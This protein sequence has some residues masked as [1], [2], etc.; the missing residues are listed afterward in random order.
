M[1]NKCLR[2]HVSVQRVQQSV[3]AGLFLVF[4]HFFIMIHFLLLNFAARSRNRCMFESCQRVK[5]EKLCPQWSC[6]IQ[7]HTFIFR[8]QRFLIL[9]V[10]FQ[11][12]KTFVDHFEFPASVQKIS[13]T[14]DQILNNGGRYFLD[15]S[16]DVKT[17][18]DAVL[19][20][21]FL[22]WQRCSFPRR[23]LI[24]VFLLATSLENILKCHP[25]L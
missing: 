8:K 14:V 11:I 20:C 10:Q 16:I 1:S 4:W 12:R 24:C 19:S 25:D 21:L 2:A 15:I 17:I 7:I 6:W 3:K 5:G 9:I 22:A 13:F 18:L 23:R